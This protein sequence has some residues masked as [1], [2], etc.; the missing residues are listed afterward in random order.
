MPSTEVRTQADIQNLPMRRYADLAA[1]GFP[2]VSW[3]S[4]FAGSVVG[5]VF[6]I[7]LAFLGVAIGASSIDPL[8]EAN[9][10]SKLG[11]GSAVWL[12]LSVVLSSYI[13]G[14]I[15]GKLSGAGRRLEAVLHGAASWAVSNIAT[16]LLLGTVFGAVISGVT[17]ATKGIFSAAG[18]A[19]DQAPGVVDQAIDTA[20]Q[21]ADDLMR[22]GQQQVQSGQAETQARQA[23]DTA[24]K[25]VAGTGWGLVGLM[26]L[27]LVSGLGGAAASA[28]KSTA[29][30]RPI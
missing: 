11:A 22:Q 14:W 15:A 18:K 5:L 25:A 26:F 16:F 19:A 2:R 27:G 3:G 4:I 21:K 24:A 23:G 9:P 30:S 29:Y 13:G 7:W 1:G 8:Q 20:Q 6:Q 17:G 28:P 10:M 12:A